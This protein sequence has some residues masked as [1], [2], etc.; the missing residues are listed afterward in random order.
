M[1]GTAHALKVGAWKRFIGCQIG[2]S[3]PQRFQ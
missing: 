2:K 1:P 3:R